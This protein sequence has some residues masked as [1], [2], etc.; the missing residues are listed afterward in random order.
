MKSKF[1]CYYNM[2]TILWIVAECIINYLLPI[3]EYFNC[4]VVGIVKSKVDMFDMTCSTCLLSNCCCVF[5]CV[6]VRV[7]HNKALLKI[8]FV[9]V[10]V[11]IFSVK[12]GSSSLILW[13][14]FY[15]VSSCKQR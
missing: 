13:V 3:I 15:C 4:K 5:N 9:R 12:C 14:A 6:V 2:F 1:R 8:N 7:R 11:R 10:F